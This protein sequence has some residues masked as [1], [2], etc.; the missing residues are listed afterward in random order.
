MICFFPHSSENYTF[1]YKENEINAYMDI[2][3][4]TCIFRTIHTDF[5][6]LVPSGEGSKV[7]VVTNVFF[8]IVLSE[9]CSRCISK[10]NQSNLIKI[11]HL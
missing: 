1:Y 4:C 10:L 3:I 5:I 8:F 9:F 6:T 11:L 7:V 2:Y